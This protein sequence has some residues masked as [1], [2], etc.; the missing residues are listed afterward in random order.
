MKQHEVEVSFP[1]LLGLPFPEIQEIEMATGCQCDPGS[2][3]SLPIINGY[4][5]IYIWIIHSKHGLTDLKL[6]F[7]A[8]T[9]SEQVRFNNY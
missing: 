9:L 6:L 2:A 4:I 1:R 3:S 8:L 5:Y 7:R